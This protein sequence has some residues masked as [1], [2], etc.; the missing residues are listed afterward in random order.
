MEIYKSLNINIRT[1]IKNSE[2]LEFVPRH[3]KTET[4]CQH[5]VKK[6]PYQ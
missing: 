1:L 2:M 3:L 4:V 6:L 5:A